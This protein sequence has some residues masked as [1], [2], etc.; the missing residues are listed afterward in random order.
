MKVVFYNPYSTKEVK[1]AGRRI[2]FL[3]KI[4]EAEG[5]PYLHVDEEC[6][7]KEFGWLAAVLNIPFFMRFL[8]FWGAYK[9]INQKDTVVISEVIFSPAWKKNFILTVHDL[10]VFNPL[11]TRGGF[12]RTWSYLIFAR[13]AHKIIVVSRSTFDDMVRF[14]K[15]D[16]KKIHIVSNGISQDRLEIADRLAGQVEKKYDFVYV[17]SFAKHKRQALLVRALPPGSSL[18]IVGRDMGYL[19]E[20]Q[21][22]VQRRSK[23]V[24]VDLLTGVDSDEDLFGILAASRCGVF[25]SVFEGF[26][27]PILEYAL[28]GMYTIAT[29]IPPFREIKEYIDVFVNCDDEEGL[30]RALG[31]AI[32]KLPKADEGKRETLRNGPYTSNS[33]RDAFLVALA[34][35]R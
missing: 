15:I 26:G 30:R 29:D 22:E 28:F 12:L 8:Q 33:I 7:R 25:P 21:L 27:I 4:L 24:R 2:Q 17:S 31:D 1:G 18:A 23:E 35:D 20:T 11:A 10:K 13:L 32:A 3:I 19:Q 14:C 5:V 34:V 16:K 9:Y 6:F